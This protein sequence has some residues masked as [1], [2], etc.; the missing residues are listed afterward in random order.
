MPIVLAAINDPTAG[1]SVLDAARA[2]SVVFGASLHAVHVRS[3]MTPAEVPAALALVDREN[4]P[5]TVL[6]GDPVEEIVH[7]ASGQDVEIV[8]VGAREHPAGPAPAGHVA[9]GV[10][11]RTSKPVLVVPPASRLRG[12]TGRPAK[13]LVPL[14]GTAESADAIAACMCLLAEAGVE[15][16]AVHVFDDA[17][18]RFW[19]EPAHATDAYI[20]EFSARWCRQPD[21]G[22]RLRS[23]S[24]PAAMMEVAE[25]EDVDLIVL[26][27]S[28][29]MSPGHARMIRSAMA[30]ATLPVLLVPVADQTDAQDVAAGS[31]KP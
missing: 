20:D 18:P 29:D 13:A 1:S 26:A 31:T 11:Q 14:E 5:L 19:D 4:V 15:L 2:M 12:G 9:L 21:V 28:Q 23:G 24:A 30:G 10:A 16:V 8:V 6:V 22:V 7:A 25:A 3:P 27:W 17:V